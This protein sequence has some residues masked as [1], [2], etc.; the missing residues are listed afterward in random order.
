M[1]RKKRYVILVPNVDKELNQGLVTKKAAIRQRDRLNKMWNSNGN[2]D[3][4][5]AVVM[6]MI[7][8]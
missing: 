4:L 1:K 2:K 7:D 3:R 8:D 5:E 6:E